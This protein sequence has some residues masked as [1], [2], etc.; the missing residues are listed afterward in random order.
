MGLR[1]GT[2]LGGIHYS[3]RRVQTPERRLC[4]QNEASHGRVWLLAS[5]HV[6]N[7]KLI[8]FQGYICSNFSNSS[9]YSHYIG[10]KASSNTMTSTSELCVADY[11]RC[12]L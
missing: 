1:P 11:C 4:T 6:H 9:K 5:I 2:S 12:G 7:T 10:T 8:R 3:W